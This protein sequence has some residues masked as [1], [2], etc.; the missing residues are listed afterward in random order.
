MELVDDA[1]AYFTA[2][3]HWNERDWFYFG[4]TLLAIGVAHEHDASVRDHFGTLPNAA[5]K[6]DPHDTRDWMP[7]AAMI[8][9]TWA[10]ATAIA[11][12]DGY[13]EGRAMLEAAAFSAVSTTL[14]KLAAGRRRPSETSQ[15][16]DW[17]HAGGSF[18]SMHASVTFAVGSVLAESGND[19]DRWI[20]RALGYG[21]ATATAYSRVRNG[22]HWLSDTVA[23]AA[24][25]AATGHFV[26]NRGDEHRKRY[27]VDVTPLD[28]GAMLRYTL[29]LQ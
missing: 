12:R 11:D 26:V 24:L 2:P 29:D 10:Y 7:T 19:D 27:S 3:L 18:P 5:T 17:R 25:G 28:G 23:A 6:P 14:V 9:L 1:G 21:L 4:G 8:G 15:V 13:S 22:Q 20:R 16:D